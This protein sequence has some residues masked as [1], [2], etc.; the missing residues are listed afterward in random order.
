MPLM[1]MN[2]ES[3]S[4][5]GRMLLLLLGSFPTV[6]CSTDT[7]GQYLVVEELTE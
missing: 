3:E 2:A 5:D 1:V 6:A 7:I 4:W